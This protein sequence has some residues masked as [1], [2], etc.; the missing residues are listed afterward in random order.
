[1]VNDK[2]LGEFETLVM[3]AL[4]RLGKDAYGVS[5]RQEI[6]SRAH[7]TAPIG[8][9]YAA[10]ERLEA[11]KFVSSHIG[12]ATAQRGG[13]RKKYF[14]LTS[15]GEAKLKATLN[16][17]GGMMRGTRLLAGFAGARRS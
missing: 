3:I 10:L 5:I 13:R 7:R 9:V 2:N 15:S 17:L 16:G 12:E 14:V 4:V 8:S 1:M 6:E 11:K